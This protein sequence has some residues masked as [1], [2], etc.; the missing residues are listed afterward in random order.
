MICYGYLR[1]IFPAANQPAANK[2]AD[3]GTNENPGAVRRSNHIALPPAQQHKIPEANKESQRLGNAV[4][5][6]IG[7][8]DGDV[9]RK[10]Q[11]VNL[12]RK[13]KDYCFTKSVCEG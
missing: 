11:A 2:C 8:P 4:Q 6:N 5:Q 13:I 9:N 1:R 10:L 3:D 12:K 7:L